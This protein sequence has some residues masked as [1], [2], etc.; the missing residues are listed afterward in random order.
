MR[1]LFALFCL[2]ARY[3]FY[4]S[5]A[6]VAIVA[7]V[8]SGTMTDR[9]NF[10]DS[11]LHR[12]VMERWGAPIVQPS[13]S[14]RY[15]PSG[16]VF[17]SLAALPLQ[18]QEVVVDAAMNYRKRGL[19]YFSGFD[20][21]FQGD[22]QA[23]NDQGRDIDIA[24]VFPIHLEKN[25]VLL[26]NLFFTVD[27]HPAK[28]DL[29]D[30]ADKLVWTGRLKAGTHVDF[31]VAFHGRGLDSFVYA[32]DPRAPVRN[33]HL[34]MHITGGVNF[35]YA[36]GVV[37]AST[38]LA[39]GDTVFLQWNYASLESG[40]PVGVILPSEK[41]YDHLIATMVRR[42]WA[43]FL[44]FF[45]GLSALCVYH[46]RQLLIYESY[47]I[48][49]SYGLFFVLLAYFAA[50]ISFYPAWLLSI[51]IIGGLLYAYLRFVLPK[52]AGRYVFGLLLS[53][54]CVPTAAV[55]LQ[56]YTGLIYTLE[57]LALLTTLMV[58]TTRPSVRELIER[59]G[60]I[61][62]LGTVPELS[63]TAAAPQGGSHVA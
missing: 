16:A 34:A 6:I 60:Q 59:L 32:L 25:K 48:A 42:G 47:L 40:I 26:S 56:G 27:G 37:P 41:S 36:D 17:N 44:L 52:S 2:P 20:F 50:F 43:P 38:T 14:V 4:G 3:H 10:A 22:Y 63:P 29:P 24:F 35:D 8:I 54:L 46:K 28:V 15:V 53:S 61:G 31:R 11:E 30:G 62:G 55:F 45:A 13:P 23:A 1:R 57:I 51:G 19:V 18:S 9:Q 58:L 12:D 49:A 7:S 33:L 39:K 21:T 5:L